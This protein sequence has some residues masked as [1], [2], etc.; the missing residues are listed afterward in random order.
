MSFIVL[1]KNKDNKTY[2]LDTDDLVTDLVSDKEIKNALNMGITFLKFSKSTF[3]IGVTS[4]ENRYGI[5][6][7]GYDKPIYIGEFPNRNNRNDLFGF[8]IKLADFGI[9]K[10]KLVI[11][12]V[13]NCWCKYDIEVPMVLCHILYSPISNIRNISYA[14]LTNEPIYFSDL[15][16]HKK[17][18]DSCFGDFPEKSLDPKYCNIS[19]INNAIS[20]FGV[21]Y[22]NEVPIYDYLDNK[23]KFNVVKGS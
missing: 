15:S 13:A 7:S 23:L 3:G 14:C 20:I 9:V 17:Q 6:V 11:A 2:I 19:I 4:K 5:Y 18:Y 21:K 16:I 22:D 12:I 10:N 1:G 8:E